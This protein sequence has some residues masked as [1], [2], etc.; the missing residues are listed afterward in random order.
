MKPKVIIIEDSSL[1][2][3]G[4]GQAMTLTVGKILAQK[5]QLKFVDFTDFS[6]YDN[7]VRKKFPDSELINVK[8]TGKRSRSKFLSWI[9]IFIG[10]FFDR[11]KVAKIILKGVDVKKCILYSTNKRTLIYA[12]YINK[13]Y[14]I[15]FI[16]H[17]HLVENMNSFY[18]PIFIKMVARA[19]K[20]ITVSNAV[21]NTIKLPQCELIYNP[22]VNTHGFKGE[23]KNDNFTV[24]YVGSLIPIKGVEYFVKASKA[25]NPFVKFKVYGVGPQLEMLKKLADER[26]IF[27]GFC[28]DIFS[29]FYNGIDVLVLPTIIPESLSMV[30]VEAKSVG[31]PVIVTDMGGPAEIVTDGVDGFKIE[32]QN[33][34]AIAEKINLLTSDLELYN[35]LAKASFESSKVFDYDT[36]KNKIERAFEI[37]KTNY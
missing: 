10:S 33:S 35:K 2:G 32:A 19:T 37:I 14:G 34:E 21:K 17:A 8:T 13:K 25:C 28:K 29:E 16:H 23:K 15:P 31:I 1:V 5:Y 30:V 26:V 22:A 27:M 24:G 4:G 7:E 6:R 12:N 9:K 11:R 20:I 3:F 36:F 18:Y